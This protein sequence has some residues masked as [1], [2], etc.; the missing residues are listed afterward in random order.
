MIVI[1]RKTDLMCVG[2]LAEG[3]TI[4]EEFELNVLPNFGGAVED[5]GIIETDIKNFELQLVDG[6]IT[7]VERIIE[8]QPKEPTEIEILKQQLI[9]TQETVDFLLM[10]GM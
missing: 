5:Y 8:L 6:T 1:Y 4:G 9:A 10:G 3:M 7:P 2:T